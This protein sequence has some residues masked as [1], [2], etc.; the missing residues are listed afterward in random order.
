MRLA[1]WLRGERP[2]QKLKQQACL[3]ALLP[4]DRKVWEDYRFFG[5]PPLP[6]VDPGLGPGTPG[7]QEL[8]P[9]AGR[10]S[11]TCLALRTRNSFRRFPRFNVGEAWCRLGINDASKGAAQLPVY[12][13]LWNGSANM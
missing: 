8:A 5:G 10:R 13:R 4:M 6:R 1:Q 2:T 3:L 9:A 7:S 11:N 12:K